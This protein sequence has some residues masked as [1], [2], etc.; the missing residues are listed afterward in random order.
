VTPTETRLFGDLVS[1]LAERFSRTGHVMQQIE[2]ENRG[3]CPPAACCLR[4]T[5][6]TALLLEACDVLEAEMEQPRQIDLF[7]EVAG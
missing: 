3:H 6:Y 2:W 4:C 5:T 1:A 7:G